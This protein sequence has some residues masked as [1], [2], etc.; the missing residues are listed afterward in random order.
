[1]VPRLPDECAVM[2]CIPSHLCDAGTAELR[3]AGYRMSNR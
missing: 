1:M 2:M 3:Q